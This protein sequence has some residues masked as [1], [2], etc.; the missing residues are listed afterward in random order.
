MKTNRIASLL[1]AS[2]VTVV[3]AAGCGRGSGADGRSAEPVH[4]VFTV[5]PV[6]PAEKSENVYPGIVKEAHTISSGFKTAGQIASILVKEGD[7]VREGQLIA[8]LDDEDYKL[9]VEALQIQYDQV[10]GEVGRLKEL[11]AKKSVSAND[12]EKAVAG[13]GQLGVQLQVNRNKLEYTKLYSPVSGYVQAVNFSASELVDAG[14]SVFTIMDVS[15]RQVVVDIPAGEYR[16]RD[17]FSSI[18]C[19]IQGGGSVRMKIL[20]IVPK[21]DGN[22]L[23]R[24][25]L[26]FDGPSADFVPGS[27]V[28]VS[29]VKDLPSAAPGVLAI[30]VSSIIYDG[31]SAFVFVVGEDSCA[32]R[33]PVI[34][35]RCHDGMVE[36]EG[37]SEG[38]NVVSA[39]AYV[40]RDGEKVKVI[41]RPSESNAGGL[42]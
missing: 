19:R 4:S 28:E 6:R 1:A 40:L 36:I 14:T 16:S 17:S 10:K 18:S 3:L 34:T 33:R 2:A 22:Q 5:E 15:R 8:C 20:G 31:G 37:L 41:A 29:I 9:G 11:Y 13:L 23:Y 35:G 42:L 26:L 32:A 39:G 12:Y 25:T 21:A 38:E 24:M 30:P 27:N 7:Y